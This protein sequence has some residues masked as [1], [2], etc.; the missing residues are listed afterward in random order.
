MVPKTAASPRLPGTT[1]AERR[2]HDT[3]ETV[4]YFTDFQ[5]IRYIEDDNNTVGIL[6]WQG[7]QTAAEE[8]AAKVT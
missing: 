7:V 8:G 2:H 3:E 6:D 1:R 4:L 5:P